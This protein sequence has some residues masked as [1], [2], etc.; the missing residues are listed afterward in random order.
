M[1]VSESSGFGTTS[2]ESML[3]IWISVKINLFFNWCQTSTTVWLSTLFVTNCS[4]MVSSIISSANIRIVI[5]VTFSVCFTHSIWGLRT[6]GVLLSR[7]SGHLDSLTDEVIVSEF[8]IDSIK[9]ALMLRFLVI[10]FIS[11]HNEI[12]V[13]FEHTIF[14]SSM[15]FL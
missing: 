13:I 4:V 6:D 12:F 15:I 10:N 2:S 5:T 8:L 3:E 14:V 11:H 7:V 9:H 1:F